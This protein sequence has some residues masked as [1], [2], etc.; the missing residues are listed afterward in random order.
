M[1]SGGSVYDAS[2]L[3]LF[4]IVKLHHFFMWM[5]WYFQERMAG[6]AA[7]NTPNTCR[8][9]VSTCFITSC[10]LYF[11]LAVKLFFFIHVNGNLSLLPAFL[12]SASHESVK[13]RKD[14]LP[15]YRVSSVIHWR[16]SLNLF[17]MR[18]F[19]LP[20]FCLPRVYIWKKTECK[21]SL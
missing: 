19:C 4:R 21:F 16:I 7:V 20:F 11:D 2:F 14:V 3:A 10:A 15:W 17:P 13:E 8:R 1:I 12:L 18:C 9:K 6:G 5:F